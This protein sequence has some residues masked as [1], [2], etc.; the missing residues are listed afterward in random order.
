MER[1]LVDNLIQG[2]QRKVQAQEKRQTA[3]KSAD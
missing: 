1:L 2:Q 3:A